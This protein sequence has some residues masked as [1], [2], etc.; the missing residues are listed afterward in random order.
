MTAYKQTVKM[1]WAQ[2]RSVMEI[3]IVEKYL[4]IFRTINL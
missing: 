2:I 1:F 4:N 3:K